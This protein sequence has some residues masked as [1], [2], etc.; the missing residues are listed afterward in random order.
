M[1]IFEVLFAVALWL[2]FSF[3]GWRKKAARRSLPDDAPEWSEWEAPDPEET[4]ESEEEVRRPRPAPVDLRDLIRQFRESLAPPVERAEPVRE[5]SEEPARSAPVEPPPLPEPPAIPA[6]TRTTP[7]ERPRS[8]L[9]GA[10]LADLQ[11]G[12]ASLAR[13]VLLREVLGPPVALRGSAEP[14]RWGV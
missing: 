2:L 3:L 10:L 13:A 7:R 1:D 11:S 12:P 5:V 8:P 4:E 6:I 14:D 9:A